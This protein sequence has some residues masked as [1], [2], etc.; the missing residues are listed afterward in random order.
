MLLT[1]LALAFSSS[2]LLKRQRQ[3]LEQAMIESQS[4]SVELLA[5][6]IEQELINAMRPPFLTLKNIP[7]QRV[8]SARM[9]RITR[10][11]PEVKEILLLRD[12]LKV[13]SSYPP[14]T[15]PAQRALIQW[16]ADRTALEQIKPNDNSMSWHLFAEQIDGQSTLF[17]IQRVNQFDQTD[18]WILMQFDIDT[19]LT[20]HVRPLL[21]EF[22]AQQPG[23]AKLIGPD[24]P[25]DDDALN[26][27]VN[28]ALP[29]WMLV[30]RS[31]PAANA[32]VLQREQTLIVTITTGV[33][34]TLIITTFAVWRELRREHAQAELR[35]RFIANVSHELKTP[36]SLIRMYAE[37]LYL[38]RLKDPEKQHEYHHTILREAER[39]STMIDNVLSL[40]RHQRVTQL[41]RLHDHDL[42]ATVTGVITDYRWR[43]EEQGL[44][45]ATNFDAVLPPV[46][47][48]EGGIRQILL[49]LLDN[50]AKF[51]HAGIRIEV[52]LH[53]HNSQVE[54]CVSDYG[55]G[56]PA[57]ERE[58]LRQ[59]FVRGH[60]LPSDSGSGLGL[61]VVDLITQ[62]HNATFRLEQPTGHAGLRAVIT[63]PIQP[64]ESP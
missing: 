40:A 29:G 30:Y 28:R 34:L 58:R 55:P 53:T 60:N 4:Q 51:G 36:L 33:I 63:F 6:H 24:Q 20:R 14:V 46:A 52:E 21:D 59:P 26:L 23:T 19:L 44:T 61:A 9:Q 42:L 49:N 45:L 43:I 62:T 11:F 12:D 38:R 48:D 10:T 15:T 56:I 64:P 25:W 50:A 22:N 57:S 35:N 32:E 37:T 1:I 13:H 31:D 41:Y 18:G 5:N 54:L 3:M 27:P 47:H 8:E 16:L 17:A 39:L 2:E 7:A